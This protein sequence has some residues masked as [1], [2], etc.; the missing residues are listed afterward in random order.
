MRHIFDGEHTAKLTEKEYN[1][2]LRRFS[3]DKVEQTLQDNYVIRS[4]CICPAP[5]DC[6]GCPFYTDEDE[7]VTGCQ[8][9]LAR[10]DLRCPS[11]FL[12]RTLIVWHPNND[13]S[14]RAQITAVHNYLLGLK[15]V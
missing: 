11:V 4:K 1:I 2:L 15:K 8:S 3:L 12:T 9:L 13:T 14:A 5:H 10:L 6:S 7:L